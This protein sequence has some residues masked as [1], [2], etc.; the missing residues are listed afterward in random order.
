MPFDSS[1]YPKNWEDI[2]KEILLRCLTPLGSTNSVEQCE[3]QYECGLHPDH[4]C[5]EINW[6]DAIYAKGKI[7]L[8]IA[9]LNQNTKDNRRK[10]L[11]ALCQ[12]CH[13]RLDMP[14]RIKHRSKTLAEKK[15][16]GTLPLFK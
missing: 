5:A 16:I 6:R 7:V 14:Y 13:N 2:R 11:K 12:R 3:C 15:A 10:N 1:K 4:R 9:H 8:T